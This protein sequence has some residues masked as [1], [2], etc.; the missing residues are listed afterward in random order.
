MHPTDWIG[1]KHSRSGRLLNGG[2]QSGQLIGPGSELIDLVLHVQ[3]AANT[4]QVD[5]LILREPLDQ[6]QPRDVA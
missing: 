4:L 1:S 5:A 6:P 2:K 3:D